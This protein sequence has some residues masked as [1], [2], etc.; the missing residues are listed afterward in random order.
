MFL[1]LDKSSFFAMHTHPLYSTVHTWSAVLFYFI[2]K[3]KELG[4]MSSAVGAELISDLEISYKD[5]KL[6]RCFVK[7]YRDMKRTF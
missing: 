2:F 5:L 1:F 6:V 3:N 4:I 7:R